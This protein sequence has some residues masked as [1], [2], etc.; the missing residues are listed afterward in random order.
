MGLSLIVTMPSGLPSKPRITA[1][2]QDYAE[3]FQKR[4]IL[5]SLARM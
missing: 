4:R 1:E 3:G 5:F 2:T